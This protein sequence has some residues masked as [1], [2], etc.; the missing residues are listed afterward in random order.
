LYRPTWVEISSA[1]FISNL[2]QM[3]QWVGDAVQILAVLK[4]DAYG[5]GASALAP[6][7]LE[8]GAALIGVSTLEEGVALRDSGVPGSILLLG[9]IYPFEN[10]DVALRNN[11]TPTVASLQAAQALQAAALRFKK[12]IGFH[13]EVDT[14]MGRIGVS[15]LGAEA[16]FDWL[17]TQTD[18]RLEGIYSH[19]AAADS[20]EQFTMEQLAQFNRLKNAVG[21]MPFQNV[22]FHIANSAAAIL[23]RGSHQDMIRPGLA[24]YG[25]AP[26]RGAPSEARGATSAGAVSLAPVLT[27]HTKIVFLKKVPAGTNISY[28]R[29]F[30]TA[31]ES[32]IATLPVGYAD[33][34][35]RAF[36]NKGVVLVKGKKCPIIGRVTMD[37]IM[38]DVTD[39]GS[40]AIGEPVILIGEQGEARIT[41]QD[42]AGWAGTVP[43]EIFC[44]ISKRVPRV[45]V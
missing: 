13:L 29:T 44:G 1:N 2:Q 11:L 28:G 4:A 17:L 24:L 8:N 12:K 26:V 25:A 37:H 7:A 45:V 34:V 38:I 14:G 23:Y 19:F 10:F 20:D 18:I 36:S 42:W 43:Y 15:P 33:G 22:R 30:K 9:G 40:V 39:S 16:I 35:P 21:K 5:H 32:E 6:V 41:A 31:R 3:K 27:W